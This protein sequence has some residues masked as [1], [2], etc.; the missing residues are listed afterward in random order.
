M[1]LSII[2]CRHDPLTGGATMRVT[3]TPGFWS[4]FLLGHKPF[5]GCY[6]IRPGEHAWRDAYAEQRVDMHL[7]ILLDALRDAWEHDH[8]DVR[9]GRHP[10]VTRTWSSGPANLQNIPRVPLISYPLCECD[11]GRTHPEGAVCNS[12]WR[13]RL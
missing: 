8:D 5:D 3:H 13:D 4:R 2:D 6:I 7:H 9:E 10:G 1:K 12:V 11:C